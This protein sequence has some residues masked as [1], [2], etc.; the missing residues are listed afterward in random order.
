M[1]PPH[2]LSSRFS[3][4]WLGIALAV[5]H[6]VDSTWLVAGAIALL[7]AIPRVVWPGISEYKL[8]ES[9]AVLSALDALH[10]HALPIQ[11][12]GSS[13]A[14]AAQGP[15]LYDLVAVILA[16]Q[17]NPRLVVVVIGLI[18]ALAVG[19]TYVACCDRFGRRVAMLSA[20]L[21]AT[22]PWAIVFSRKIWPN[23]L[24]APA[25]V[26]AL[27][28][29][30]R[31]TNPKTAVPGLG[32][33]W[34]ALAA[35][36]SL[37]FGAWPE[38]MVPALATIVL[39][40][41][42]QGRA[43][44]WSLLGFS[45]FVVSL[46]PRLTDI[47][48]IVAA[49]LARQGGAPA[50][51]L[52]PFGY[53]VQLAGTDAFQILAGPSTAF[54]DGQ[55]IPSIG[56]GLQVL[57]LIG[58]AT[59]SVRLVSAAIGRATRRLDDGLILLWWLAPAVVSVAPGSIEVYIH[60]FVGTFP[61]QFVLIA[62]GITRIESGVHWLVH[63]ARGPTRRLAM[64]PVAI[65]STTAV[66]AAAIQLTFFAGFLHFVAT[67]PSDT[68]FG[69]PLSVSMDAA[70]AVR[71][72][73]LTGS[74]VVLS[75]G[76]EVGVD[77]VPTV[78]ASLTDS[79]DLIYVDAK[80]TA[81][82]PGDPISVLYVAPDARADALDLLAPWQQPAGPLRETENIGGP[83]GFTRFEARPVG[84]WRPIDWRGLG[85]PLSDGADML[86]ASVPRQARSGQS[87]LVDVAWRIGQPPPQP[88][89]QSVFAHLVAESGTQLADLDFS[90][91][92]RHPWRDGDVVINRY[93]LPVP[94]QAAAGRY[95]VDVGRYTRPDL[96]PVRLLTANKQPGPTSL[97]LGPVAVPP[98]G[99]PVQG[100]VNSDTAFGNQ[101]L[102]DGWK[103][104]EQPDTLLVTLRWMPEVDPTESYTIFVHLLDA[105]GRIVTQDDSE[106]RHGAFPT[107]TWE[108]NNGVTDTHR[109]GL[110]AVPDGRYRV[111]IGIYQPSTGQ[112][113]ETDR[114]D[115]DV[116][117][118]VDV[119]SR[120]L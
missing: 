25:A 33:T 3:A 103:I 54:D 27:W 105:T 68:F 110:A 42:R 31:A 45:V 81:I 69:T 39:P 87:L 34:V 60:H 76:D 96:A 52:S 61:T 8:D 55:A 90:P 108:K 106:P 85:V 43:G 67:H 109:L 2:G 59:T 107:S 6:A 58:A 115:S 36:V 1:R 84:A 113:L 77:T 62:L 78:M 51:N 116:L 99:R 73:R 95:W 100:F 57:L 48:A 40:R 9:T 30:L 72:D 112:R 114:G 111:E 50:I 75:G 19:L 101:I 18:N 118:S 20:I 91:L 102:L 66:V 70:S 41:T 93:A 98:R 29:L 12:Q 82:I 5:Q 37:N 4:T 53:I 23:D 71:H 63:L 16:V 49:V 7:A 14:G 21:F 65:G 46:I 56:L 44:I 83:D 89:D 88:T 38:A 74:V 47:R 17:P 64:L 117:T 11:G 80:R 94:V 22:A 86:T 13:V 97:R 104:Q 26:V 79:A 28:G 35:L 119:K 15:L 92:P 32:R 10:H 24:L 120:G